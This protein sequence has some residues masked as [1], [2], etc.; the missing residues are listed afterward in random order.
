LADVNRF[1]SDSSGAFG[2][3]ID[4]IQRRYA[5]RQVG[6]VGCVKSATTHRLCGRRAGKDVAGERCVIEGSTHPTRQVRLLDPRV[7]L[8]EQSL[9]IVVAAEPS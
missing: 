7:R 1:A 6:V 8:P 9:V 5:D 3:S 2:E 4:V